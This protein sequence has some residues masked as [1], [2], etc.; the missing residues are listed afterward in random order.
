MG[1]KLKKVKIQINNKKSH[2]SN[3]KI[4]D[5]KNVLGSPDV[6]CD[7]EIAYANAAISRS[8]KYISRKSEAGDFPDF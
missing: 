3:A 1:L 2:G 8:Q 4:N 6:F 7:R 5:N